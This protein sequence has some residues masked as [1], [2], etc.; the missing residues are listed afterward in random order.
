MRK[1][2]HFLATGF[3]S[4]LSPIAPGTTGSFVAMLL[5]GLLLCLMNTSSFFLIA[6]IITI[7]GIFVCN[8]LYELNFYTKKDPGEVVIDEWAGYFIAATHLP[9]DFTSLFI[10]FFLFRFFDILKPFPIRRIEK[11]PLGYGIV[12]DDVLAGLYANLSAQLLLAHL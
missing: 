10:A 11:L 12:L 7:I 9:G 3:Y 1:F 8:K 4:G 2:Y 6:V 5:A